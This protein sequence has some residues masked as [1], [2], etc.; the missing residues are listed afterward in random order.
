[1]NRPG[2]W[3]ISVYVRRRGLDDVIAEA[4]ALTLPSPAQNAAPFQNPV[5]TIPAGVLVGGILAL[6]GLETFQW[7]KTLQQAQPILARAIPLV[8]GMLMLLGIGL[9]VYF[10]IT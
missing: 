9:G 4:G 3:N 10:F 2:H 5:P 6:L 1:L 8:G 7:R